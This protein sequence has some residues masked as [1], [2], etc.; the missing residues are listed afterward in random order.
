[1]AQFGLQ[2]EPAFGFTYEQVADLAHNC[3]GNGFSSIWS[4]DHFMQD[5]TNP[6]QNCLDCWTLLTALAVEV[7]D[8]RL[9]SLVTCMSYRNPAILAKI[10]ASVD[11]ISDGRLEFG[12][13]AGWKDV[14]YHAYGI[15]FPSA[16]ER[17]DRFIEGLEIIKGLWTQPMTTFNGKYYNVENAVSAPKPTQKPHPPV[18]IGGSKPRMLRVMA[19]H[20]DAVNM[21]GA[22]DPAT[23]GQTLEKLEQACAEEG[24]NFDRIRKSHF[25]TFV[26]GKTEQDVQQRVQRVAER[27]GLTPDE[28]RARRARAYIGDT[29]GAVDL[30]K[31]YTELG[32]TQFMVVF[33]FMEE[34]ESMRLFAD[35][36]IPKV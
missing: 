30:L 36:V 28:Y 35:E 1:M 12:V 13:G 17:V 19:R 10:A 24:S 4:S 25:M 26:V 2:I 5:P 16:G 32:V 7:K 23:Y 11:M 14:E 31:R 21:G 18:L 3:S 15:P 29:A 33:P 27:E 22:P 20:A 34:K 8:I 9:G 6:D